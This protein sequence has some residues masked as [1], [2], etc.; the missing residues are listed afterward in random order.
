M[1]METSMMMGTRL[2]EFHIEQGIGL[3]IATRRRRLHWSQTQL[4]IMI[5][6]SRQSITAYETGECSIPAARLKRILHALRVDANFVDLKQGA[7]PFAPKGDHHGDLTDQ[8]G[9]RGRGSRPR[10]GAA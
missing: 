5:G 7:K 8:L 6:C 3:T 1:V 2:H 10:A 9:N 4:A